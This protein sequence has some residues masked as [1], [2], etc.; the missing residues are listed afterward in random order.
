MIDNEKTNKQQ[1]GGSLRMIENEKTNKPKTLKKR[2]KGNLWGQY[3]VRPSYFLI[4]FKKCSMST[5][6]TYNSMWQMGDVCGMS[7]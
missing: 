5:G 2:I 3:T 4:Q 6:T 1:Q 7:E